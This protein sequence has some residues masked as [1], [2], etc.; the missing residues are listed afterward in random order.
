MAGVGA[1][2]R[3]ERAHGDGRRRW[4]WR[5]GSVAVGLLARQCASARA[6]AGSRGGRKLVG[7]LG[8]AGTGR[9]R[10]EGGNGGRWLGARPREDPGAFYR[11]G[12][13]PV[14]TAG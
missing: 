2:D 10:R 7:R 4:P 5:L 9:A 1:E 12:G 13:R 6:S 14:M 11:P 3:P 8:C